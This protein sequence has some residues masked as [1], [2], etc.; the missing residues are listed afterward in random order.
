MAKTGYK[1][2]LGK[3]WG[4]KSRNYKSKIQELRKEAIEA[5]QEQ[6]EKYKKKME[7]IRRKYRKENNTEEEKS[8]EDLREYEDLTIFDKNKYEN[9]QME[10]YEVVVIGHVELSKAEKLVLQLHPKFCVVDKL[11]EQEFEQEQEAALAKLRMEIAR[12][13]EYSEMTQEE[14][15]KAQ[16]LEAKTRQVY[17]P[18]EKV[19]KGHRLKRMC[20]DN[21]TK[22]T[23]YA[24]R[25]NVGNKEKVTEGNFQKVHKQEC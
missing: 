2:E 14:I 7:H 25:S 4:R 8:P 11:S 23:E 9:L 15:V 21:I 6:T 24:R 20:K 16:E 3:I 1:K 22:A 17:D 18:C 12:E 19:E 13:D 5:K 10:S